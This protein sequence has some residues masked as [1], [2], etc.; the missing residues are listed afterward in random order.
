MAMHTDDEQGAGAGEATQSHEPIP[1]RYVA[2]CD[3]LGFS[4]R[5]TTEFEQTLDTYRKFGE[6][7]ADFSFQ[8]VEV[9]VYSDAVLVVGDSL[10]RILS[11]V[12]SIW[13]FA[14]AHDFMLRG[15]ITKG[16][17]WQMRRNNHLLVASDA[18][19][20][21]VKLEEQISVP[22]VFVADDIEVP[23]SYWIWR[24]AQGPLLTPIL[25]F[26]DRNIVNPFNR[27][28]FRSAHA[29]ATKL[30]TESPAHKDKYLWFLALHEAVRNDEGLVPAPVLASFF[31]RGFSGGNQLMKRRRAELRRL[32]P[33][34]P[35]IE[36]K[37]LGAR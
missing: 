35:R 25:H 8:E 36:V 4:N 17:Y 27:V 29:R 24:F 23:D 20:R 14:L 18:L 15:A 5:I 26:R 33:A 7:L 12:Q 10:D 3:I 16:L 6:L 21:A 13:F 19:V 2:F 37:R 28:W 31:L 1:E 9:T 11:A 22:A 32:R 30:M 34:G